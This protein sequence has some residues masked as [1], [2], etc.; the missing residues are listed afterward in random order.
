MIKQTAPTHKY[1]CMY[2]HAP[3]FSSHGTRS[4]ES[5]AGGCC[6]CCCRALP[7]AAPA[8]LL[9]IGGGSISCGGARALDAKKRARGLVCFLSCVCCCCVGFMCLG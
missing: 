9:A 3:S 7:P 5:T 6:C 4:S 2:I 1:T 8:L